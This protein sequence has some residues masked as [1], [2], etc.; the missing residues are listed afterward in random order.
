MGN[1]FLCGSGLVLEMA[2]GLHDTIYERLTST[3]KLIGSRLIQLHEEY[4][5]ITRSTTRCAN[6]H[7]DTIKFT[8]S[9]LW[10]AL[11]NDNPVKK[12]I[13]HMHVFLN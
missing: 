11:S 3:Q 12:E 2:V 6:I 7:K 13:I 10:N 1:V 9:K 8:G 5:V 4:S